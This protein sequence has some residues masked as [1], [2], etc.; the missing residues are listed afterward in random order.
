MA[1]PDSIRE[2]RRQAQRASTEAQRT[3]ALSLVCTICDQAF[4]A[5]Y[6]R[7]TCSL[8]CLRARERQRRAA[9]HLRAAAV[10]EREIARHKDYRKRV[11]D[12][13]PR[14]SARCSR[15][16]RWCRSELCYLCRPRPKRR[17]RIERE[18]AWCHVAFIAVTPTQKFCS[19]PHQNI[20]KS[21][22]RKAR[23]RDVGG[24]LPSVWTIYERDRGRCAL[25]RRKV[26]R[27]YRWPDQRT[28][29]LDHVVPLSKGGRD[30][31]S[32]VQL[33]HLGCNIRKQ[34]RRERLF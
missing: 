23:L 16:G 30:E 17:E 18:C 19:R 29:S 31:P 33:A 8:P 11:P 6:P 25:C 26:G 3:R 12:R 13:R 27:S 2:H 9:R 34:A 32:N 1:D 7:L 20:A 15:C 4:I 21:K 24:E 22:R 28:A 14:K 5:S 10:R